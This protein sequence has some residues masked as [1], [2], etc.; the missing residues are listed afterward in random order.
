M[1]YNTKTMTTIDNERMIAEF[2]QLQ[3]L[4]SVYYKHP[5][6]AKNSIAIYPMQ[7]HFTDL[8]YHNSWDWLMPVLRKIRKIT[9]KEMSFNEYEIW[10]EDFGLINPFND[11]FDDCFEYVVKFINWFNNKN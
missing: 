9:L 5:N 10:R 1:N 4:N 8:Q 2:M 3:K 6:I 7:V 11:S